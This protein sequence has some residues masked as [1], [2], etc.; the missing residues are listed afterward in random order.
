MKLSYL[1]ETAEYR[2][3]RIIPDQRGFMAQLVSTAR[4]TISHLLV[5]ETRK[6]EARGNHYHKNKHE[7][8]FVVSGKIRFMVKG[9]M[10]D[11]LGRGA[12]IEIMPNEP[13]AFMA[14]E[15]SIVIEYSPDRYD[16]AD[17]Y[18]EVLL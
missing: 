13:H 14:L 6:G 10:D 2:E 4:P 3:S 9:Q 11:V 18:K 16:A 7:Y 17:N 12:L 15:D 5:L 1:K 8:F